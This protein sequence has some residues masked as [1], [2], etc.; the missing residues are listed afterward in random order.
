MSKNN[1]Y[2]LILAGGR[3]TRF[4]P[5]SR[6]AH[7]KQVLR[8]LGDRSLI[9][10]TV[11][12]LASGDSARTH[13]DSH[14]RPPARRDRPPVA[15]GPEAARSWPNPPSA[16]P[17]RA[18]DSRAHILA[19]HRSRSR[20]GRL[21]R[22]SCHRASPL[23]YLRLLRPAFQ[24]AAQRRHRRA[25]HPAALARNR[26]RLYR[27]SQR[28]PGR[29]ARTRRRSTV[30]ARSRTSPPP[31]S[32]SRPATSIGTPACSSGRPR[33]CLTPSANFSPRPP[34]LLASPAP[35]LQPQVPLRSARNLPAVRE[36]LDRLRRA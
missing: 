14:Q 25:R 33:C 24:A 32:S 30:S 18:S 29:L 26:L 4:W 2:G 28:R 16:T 5:R 15:R 13:L 1:R 6:R 34:T 12:R 7:A 23:A 22:R 35:V 9:Q 21:S 8:F 20:H 36:H 31:K 11:D 3:G 17:R 10:Q 27:I 19:I